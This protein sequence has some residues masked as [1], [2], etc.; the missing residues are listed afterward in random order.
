MSSISPAKL[1]ENVQ[2]AVLYKLVIFAVLMA[3]VP[4]ATYF[5]SLH[6]VLKNSTTGAAISAIVTANAVLVGWV[7]V[8]FREESPPAEKVTEGKKER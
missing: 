7:V 1:Q 2:V 6:Y 3:V 8:A 5:V 4:I